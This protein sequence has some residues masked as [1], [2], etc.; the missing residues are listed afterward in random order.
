[1]IE[2]YSNEEMR[3]KFSMDNKF[4]KMLQIELAVVKAY[5]QLGKIPAHTYDLMKSKAYIDVAEI[6]EVEKE[7]KHDVIAFIQVAT[8][9]M[10]ECKRW[11]H[12]GLTSTDV[13]DSA[14]SLM[15]KD[16][17]DML[18]YDIQQML[19][20]LK[21]KALQYKDTKIMGRTHG[22]QA[23]ITSFGLKWLLWYDEL[24]RDYKRFQFERLNVEVIK[25]SGAVGNYADIDPAIEEK[26]SDILSINSA[27]IATQV[28]SRDRHIGYINSLAMISSLIEKIAIEIRNLSRSEISEVNEAFA[29]GQ[30][31]SSA[32]PHKKNPIASENMCGCARLMKSYV[33]VSYDNNPL[34][35]ER[36]ISHSS[37]ERVILS[38]SC[39][40]L[41]YMLKRY[42]KVLKNLEVNQNNIRRNINLTKG[43]IFSPKV[44]LKL[45]SKGLTRTEAY[46][47]V[48][49]DAFEC[50][51]K[52]IEFKELLSKDS[53]INKIL[54]DE[55]I[56]SCFNEDS[57][58]KNINQIYKKVLK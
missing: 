42:S 47:L 16:A 29:V 56:D 1:M 4:Q 10:G 20:V 58:L 53:K 36:D 30:K 50:F 37:S 7:T 41:D 55:E 32:M 38:D 31:G 13:V 25:L 6:A 18:D 9:K 52:N 27:D 28:L 44:L 24:M 46:S 5:E 51:E 57:Q 54:T 49:T 35:G 39:I 19:D 22:M 34:W 8:S 17:N 21:S 14:N 45:M 15:L 40:L 43:V 33:G 48:Q 11:F 23:E 12:Y 26:V 3:R 2:R